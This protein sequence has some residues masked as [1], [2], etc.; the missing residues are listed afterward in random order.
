MLGKNNIPDLAQTSNNFRFSAAVAG[1]GMILRNSAYKG[2]ANYDL[3][4][5]LGK[6]ALGAD[7]EGYRTEF[8]QM[9]KTASL[10]GD[11]STV[12]NK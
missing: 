11:P 9:V 1:F 12:S 10:L 4:A 8:L 7:E 2:S 5:N 6:N 3:V